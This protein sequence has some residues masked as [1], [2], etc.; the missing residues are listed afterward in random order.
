MSEKKVTPKEQCQQR[1]LSL[2]KSL[3]SLNEAHTFYLKNSQ[4]NIYAM[5]LIQSFEFSFE[6]CWVV[7][8]YFIQHKDIV[9]LK[10]ARAV[11]KQAFK[12]GI[13]QNGDLWIDMLETRNKLSHVYSEQMAR[14]FVEKISKKYVKEMHNMYHFLKKEL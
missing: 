6:L 1:L 5:A 12:N 13:I 7:V 14:E 9:N 3:V 4:N 8:K 10:Y 2:E 11:I